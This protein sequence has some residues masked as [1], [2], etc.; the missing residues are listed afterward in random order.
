[1][2][3]EADMRVARTAVV[4]SAMPQSSLAGPVLASVVVAPATGRIYL[5][6]QNVTKTF[7]CSFLSRQC[8]SLKLNA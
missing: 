1:V 8:Q 7:C 3:V 6:L 5:V 4:L 2:S